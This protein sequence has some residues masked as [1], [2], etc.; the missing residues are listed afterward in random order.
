M[1]MVYKSGYLKVI[2]GP[3]KSGKSGRFI[4][5]F[6]ELEFSENKWKAFKPAVNTREKGIVSRAFDLFLEATVVN[7]NS[8]ELILEH[9]QEDQF[10]IIGIDE[11]QFFNNRLVEVVDRLLRDKYHVIVSGLMLNFRGEPF[12]PMPYIIGRSNEITR[13]TA[14]CDTPGCDQRA[15]RTQRLIR[16]KPAQYD[17]PLV[18]IEGQGEIETYE[19]RCV[20]HHY[21]QRK[22]END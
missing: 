9:L 2:F 5:I 6:K 13:L 12:G 19:A 22:T 20:N 16:G 7:E 15:T 10:K 1:S 8:P 18:V 4:R 21:V 11:A 14:I 3:M 17:S